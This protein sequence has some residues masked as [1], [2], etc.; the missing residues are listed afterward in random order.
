MSHHA[1]PA[2]RALLRAAITL[3]AVGAALAVG[4]GAA[5]ADPVG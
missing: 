3:S 1:T 5:Q 4:A 2:P